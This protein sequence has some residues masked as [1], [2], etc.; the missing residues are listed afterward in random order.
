MTQAAARPASGAK[1]KNSQ[2]R[3][4]WGRLKKNRRAMVSLAFIILL[5]LTALC[6]DFIADYEQVAI[7]QNVIERLQSPSAAHWFGTDYYGRDMFARVVHGTRISI[8]LGFGAASISILLATVVGT[9]AAYFGGRVDNVITRIV[10]T[11]MAIPSLLLALAIV[12]SFGVGLPQLVVALSAGQI[13]NFTR[14]VRSASISVVNQ[15]FI[16]AAKARGASHLRI[17]VKYIV[18]NIIGTILIQGTMQVSINI[19]MGSMMSF[20]GLGVQIPRPEWGSMLGEGLAYMVYS[21]HLV[22]IPGICL[23][24]TALAI[25]SFGDCLRDA[26]DP[27]LKG[28]A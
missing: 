6:A 28:K 13:A 21:P 4:I 17:I 23:M 14:M 22:V 20:V 8:I 1:K 15:E 25:N 7:K 9:S 18:P 19:L 2:G 5:F 11:L 10:D 12:A 3:E 27:R 26:F 24:L 16:E